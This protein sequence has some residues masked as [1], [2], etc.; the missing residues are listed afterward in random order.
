MAVGSI[1]AQRKVSEIL[2][3]WAEKNLMADELEI[4]Y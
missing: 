2:L 3:E 1:I 4:N